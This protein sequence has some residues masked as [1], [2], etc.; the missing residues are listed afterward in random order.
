MNGDLEDVSKKI[1]GLQCPP[2]CGPDTDDRTTVQPQQQGS[3]VGSLG[4]LPEQ[5]ANR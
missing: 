3:Q 5:G 2:N 1:S 4:N